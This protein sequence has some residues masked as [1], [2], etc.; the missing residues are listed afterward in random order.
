MR[1]RAGL[2]SI[3]EP[4]HAN[5]NGTAATTSEHDE[6]HRQFV[7]SHDIS[8]AQL[9]DIHVAMDAQSTLIKQQEVSFD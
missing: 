6:A 9:A 3:D 4:F 7:Q 1:L 8:A 5:A 2:D